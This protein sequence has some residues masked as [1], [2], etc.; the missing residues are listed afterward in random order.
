MEEKKISSTAKAIQ[1]RFFKALNQCIDDKKVE[2]LASFCRD[3]ELN[4]P[5]YTKLRKMTLNP[6]TIPEG[7]K[8]K[9]IDIDVLAYLVK[10]AGVSAEWLLTGRGKTF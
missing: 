6:E 10:D 8:Y 5:R 1:E 7:K 9:Y 3:H 4:R 2:S